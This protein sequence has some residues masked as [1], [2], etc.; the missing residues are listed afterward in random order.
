M[1]KKEG[2]SLTFVRAAWLVILSKAAIASAEFGAKY[3][4]ELMRLYLEKGTCSR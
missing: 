1:L 4:P 3:S 2:C